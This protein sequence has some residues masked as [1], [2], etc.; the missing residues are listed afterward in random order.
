VRGHHALAGP[1]GAGRVEQRGLVVLRD[2][3]L[4]AR[5]VGR[6]GGEIFDGGDDSC[7]VALCVSCVRACGVVCVVW[8]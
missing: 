1:R 4:P 2:A 6:R 5:G 7:C 8:L 3:V